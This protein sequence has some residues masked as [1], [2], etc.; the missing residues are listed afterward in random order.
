MKINRNTITTYIFILIVF[1]ISLLNFGS[2]RSILSSKLTSE[3]IRSFSFNGSEVDSL[4]R[5]S[6]KNKNLYVDVYGLTQLAL[7]KSMIGNFEFVKDKHGFM[8]MFQVD[9]VDETTADNF[10]KEIGKLKE[11]LDYKNIPLLYV[12]VPAKELEGYTG[13][14]EGVV[15]NSNEIMDVIIEGSSTNNIQYL[16]VRDMIQEQNYPYNEVYLKT[17]IHLTTGS[18]F[19]ILQNIINELESRFSLY[20]DNKN[21]ILDKGNY[22]I[23]NKS[24]LGNLGR[25][26]GRFFTGLDNFE[27]YYPNFTTDMVLNNYSNGLVKTGEFHNTVMN[28]YDSNDYNTYWVTNYLQ[29]PSPY[30]NITNNNVKSNNILVLM[31]PMGLRTISYLSLMCNNVTILDPRYFNGAYYLEQALDS[32]SYDAV[33]VLQS[34]NLVYTNLVQK[35]LNAEIVSENTPTEI[36]RDEKY[37]VNIT[38]KNTSEDNWTREKSIRLGIFQDGIDHGYRLDLPENIEISPGETYTFTLYDFQA[39]PSDNTYIEYQMLREGI[40]YFGEKQRVDIQVK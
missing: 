18:E 20:F 25:A 26:S 13:L 19:W 17:D 30:Y 39:P 21:F 35:V 31:D 7:N 23:V 10:V 22:N 16:D 4:F 15:Q 27:L 37:N 3:A 29:W 5:T 36:L 1:T 24:M 9:K 34:T 33:I 28:G 14:E 38:V 12:Q 2:I 8:H 40:T 6:I 32:Q 11:L